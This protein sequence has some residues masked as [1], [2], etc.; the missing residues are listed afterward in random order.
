MSLCVLRD[1]KPC[2]PCWGASVGEEYALARESFFSCLLL[3]VALGPSCVG[4]SCCYACLLCMLVCV[5]GVRAF[6]CMCMC[7]C[8]CV[9]VRLSCLAILPLPIPCVCS[10]RMLARACMRVCVFCA[11]ARMFACQVNLVRE[12]FCSLV[13][14]CS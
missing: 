14:C 7:V 10:A 12:P 8:V 3:L 2:N 4:P 11:H 6:F 5:C 9:C 1:G 13:V